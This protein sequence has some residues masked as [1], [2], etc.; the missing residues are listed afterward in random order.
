M[1]IDLQLHSTYSDGYLTPTGL[2]KFIARQG[3]KVAALTDHN[4]VS[5]L[6]EFR[7]A[8]RTL[9]IKPITGLE[10]YIKLHNRRFNILWFNFDETSPELHDMLRDSQVRRRRQIRLLLNKL[11]KRGFKLDVNRT[12]DKYNHY[13]PVNHVVDDI[14]AIP[15][16]A[17]KIRRRL[18]LKQPRE[19][20]IIKE[21]FRNPDIGI[22][23]NS[24]IDLD[25]V[26]KLRKKIGGQLVLCHPAKNGYVGRGFLKDLKF[27]GL[28]GIEVMSPHHS[29]GAVVHLQHLARE[30]NLVEV[31][32]SD[33]HRLEGH[34]HPIQHAWQYYQV[35]SKLLKG[36]R[37]IIG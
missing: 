30:L 20:D 22:L 23:R 24:F 31:G 21:Y 33:F 1:L 32:G 8:C 19:G 25:N 14:M 15:Y 2:A 28:D 26:V 4:T 35:E 9:K 16:N 3:V 27:M 36:V 34:G 12:L 29:Y 17:R 18:E 37:K 7:K 10:L 5:G 6:D 11:I 13:V